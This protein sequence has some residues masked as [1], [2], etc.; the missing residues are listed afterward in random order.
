MVVVTVQELGFPQG[1]LGRLRWSAAGRQESLLHP[2]LV[3]GELGQR[4]CSQGQEQDAWSV[5]LQRV[6]KVSADVSRFLVRAGDDSLSR[7]ARP[8]GRMAGDDLN[9]EQTG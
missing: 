6:C 4:V 1:L 7:I 2:W 3:R 5:V 9:E 8:W